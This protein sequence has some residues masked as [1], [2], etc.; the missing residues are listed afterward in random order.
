MK[1]LNILFFALFCSNFVLDGQTSISFLAGTN[2]ARGN[3]ISGTEMRVLTTHKGKVYGGT[4][5]WMDDTTGTCDP[6]IGAMIVRLDLP[7]GSWSLDKHFNTFFPKLTGRE[8]KRNEG[9]TALSSVVFTKDKLG[10]PLPKP[11]TIL[12]AACR[13]FTGVLSV[14]TRNDNTGIW[15]ETR[16]GDIPSDTNGNDNDGTIRSFALYQ[17]KVT[18]VENIFAGALP[19]GLI[20]GVYDSSLPGKIQWNPKPELTGFVGRPMAF[21]RCNGDL[22]CAI[23]PNVWKRNDG[24]N[25]SWSTVYTYPF[26]PTPGGSSGLRGLTTVKNPNNNTQSLLAALEGGNG[27]IARLDLVGQNYVA[28]TEKNVM[29]DLST[30]WG[31]PAAYVVVANSNMTWVNDP[32]NGDSCLVITIQH[33]PANERD[34]AF[35]YIRRQNQQGVTY[36]LLRLENNLFAPFIALNSTRACV[37]SPFVNDPN[38]VYLGGYDAD[39]NVSHNTAYVLRVSSNDLFKGTAQTAKPGLKRHILKPSLTATGTSNTFGNHVAY[40]NT[41]VPSQRKL[42]VFFPGTGTTPNAYDSFDSLAANLGFHALGLA[43]PNDP[44]VNSLC[45]SSLDSFCFDKVRNEII[46]GTEQSTLVQV[47]PVNSIVGR[48]RSALQSLNS[49]YPT[50][51]WGQYLTGNQ[52]NWENIIVAGHS[53]GGGHAGL[54]AKQFSVHKAIMLAAPK[55][56]FTNLNKPAHW[57]RLAS[58]TSA[59]RY[60]GFT[61]QNDNQGCT[62][63]QQLQNYTLLGMPAFGAPTAV[64]S[65]AS[66]FNSSHT[67]IST[68]PGLSGSNAHNIVAVDILAANQCG[69]HIFTPVWSYLLTAQCVTTSTLEKALTTNQ[70]KIYPQPFVDQL[71][72]ESSFFSEPQLVD[73]FNSSGQRVSSFTLEA[74]VQTINLNLPAGFYFLKVSNQLYKL[75]K[76]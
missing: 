21:A 72:I 48:L 68:L 71:T 69:K 73:I 52:L 14:Y 62:P 41:A 51:N 7:R 16:I 24:S 63:L 20:S 53:Q 54:M 39:N 36:Q 74:Q 42:M 17:D 46:N 55:D 2:D 30:T 50:E 25:P 66:T 28:T 47:N 38:F 1:K 9:V 29:T 75:V 13:D 12:I 5:T 37:K 26:T 35:Y 67:L 61:H 15:I 49:Q 33:H 10:K 34:D 64:E 58:Q 19:T 56:Y 8:R 18:G 40:L 45:S 22:F 31:Y 6:F 65:T 70:L 44:T 76:I 43:Y 11:D 23:A 32:S 59:C 4:E 60:F 3:F 57:Y 27:V